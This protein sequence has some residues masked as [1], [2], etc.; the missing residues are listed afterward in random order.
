MRRAETG[1]SRP[2]AAP[3]IDSGVSADIGS[4]RSFSVPGYVEEYLFEC[5]SAVALDQIR[6]RALVF[7]S[8]TSEHQD[9]A[10]H[11]ST[12]AILWLANRIAALVRF[13]YASK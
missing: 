8:A 3:A 13:W 11:R 9:M 6:W 2:R 7:Q 4:G 1:P 12:S 5:L 10:A